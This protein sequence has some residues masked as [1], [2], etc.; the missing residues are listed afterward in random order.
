MADTLRAGSTDTDG[1]ASQCLESTRVKMAACIGGDD[2][3]TGAI[4]L[5]QFR[6]QL[7]PYKPFTPHNANYSKLGDFGSIRYR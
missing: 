4:Y 7:P 6:P 5:G 3:S 2:I 1:S